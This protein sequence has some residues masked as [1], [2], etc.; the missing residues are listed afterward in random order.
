MDGTTTLGT[1][2][3]DG[4]G[5]ASLTTM[6]LVLGS[7]SII[8]SYGGDTNYSSSTSPAA[9][10][11]V[12]ASSNTGQSPSLITLTASDTNPSLFSPVQFSVN[13]ATAGPATAT[14]TGTVAFY[15]NGV[16]VDTTA[17]DSN[18]N[19][20]FSTSDL[21]LGSETIVA[22]YQGDADYSPSTSSGSTI[23][24]GTS[25]ELFL[26]QMY[27]AI[28]NRPIDP[29]GL[30]DW[31]TALADGATRTKVVKD[32]FDSAEAKAR[33]QQIEAA[34]TTPPQPHLTPQSST[35]YK[36]ER[37]NTYYQDI[38]GRPADPQEMQQCIV[39]VDQGYHGKQI[40]IDLLG[41]QDY[42]SRFDTGS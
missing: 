33:A 31:T 23:M 16:L 32:I 40:A 13:V 38:L 37:I 19:A 26:N 18:G 4:N 39:L 17:L 27:V 14:P 9:V 29:V 10:A 15:A 30:Q 24:V 5:N 7:N 41:S 35:A 12:N 11:T 3:L 42:F 34:S 6:A 28:L 36:E 20:T 21:E 1:A 2:T 8:A 22:A 25:T